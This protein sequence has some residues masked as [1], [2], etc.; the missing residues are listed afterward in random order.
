MILSRK[1]IAS[2]SRPVLHLDGPKL[3]AA[4]ETVVSRSEGVGG[5]EFLVRGVQFKS[6]VVADVFKRD[7]I[8]ALDI[9]TFLSVVAFMAPVR[10]RI[11]PWLEEAG[12]SGMETIRTAVASLLDQAQA[13]SE[14]DDAVRRFC[15]KFPDGRGYRWVRDLAAEILHGV[16]PERYPLMNRWVWDVKAN[17]GVIRELWHDP[18]ID[19]M[20]LDVP[21]NYDTFLMLREELSQY[22]SDNGV[23]RDVMAYVD[24]LC[25]QIY[26]DYICE[27]GGSYLRT[28]FSAAE[29][30]LQYTRR[31]LGLEGI[32]PETGRTRAKGIEG[33][34]II[35][36]IDETTH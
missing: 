35:L 36:D 25:A 30:P 4:L 8:D 33:R 7:G 19:H 2:T 17:T 5:I 1:P 23:F 14:C 34:P 15:E 21:D 13:A 3:A 24:I 12:T 6:E 20:T 18:N 28:D 9:D 26:A 10:R 32:D 27:Q 29:D 16:M 22:L 11:G 31:M